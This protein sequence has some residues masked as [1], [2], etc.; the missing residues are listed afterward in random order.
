MASIVSSLLL[1]LLVGGLSTGNLV[2]QDASRLGTML[3]DRMDQLDL[4]D[5]DDYYDDDYDDEDDWVYVPPSRWTFADF[6]AATD[7]AART[8]GYEPMG[9]D[10][11]D[12]AEEYAAMYR[13]DDMRLLTFS[14]VSL[15]ANP[16]W[17]EEI[18][19]GMSQEGEVEIMRVGRHE[20]LYF[21]AEDMEDEYSAVQS[22]SAIY[23]GIRDKDAI[24]IIAT[25][26]AT[27][28]SEMRRIFENLGL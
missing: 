16:G 5:E 4:Y 14:A 28:P 17:Y 1:L 26:P 21:S 13:T 23:T 27:S 25:G 11:M 22:M 15:A 10:Y 3:Q 2:A 8:A 24:L 6:K 20:L 7:R 18:L 12:P 9:A 19:Y